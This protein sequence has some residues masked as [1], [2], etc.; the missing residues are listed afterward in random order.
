MGLK[1]KWGEVSTAIAKIMFSQEL[2]KTAE[3]DKLSVADASDLHPWASLIWGGNCRARA[4]RLRN[5]GWK[6][7]GP[8]LLDSLTPMIAEE[9]KR[10]RTQTSETTSDA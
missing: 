5:L 10:F 8:V 3:V 6:A 4:D 7:T 2:L 9:V 1:Q